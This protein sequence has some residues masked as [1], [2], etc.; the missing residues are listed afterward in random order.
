[1]TGVQTCALPISTGQTLTV[2]GITGVNTTTAFVNRITVDG[3]AVGI[4]TH[5]VGGIAPTDG[6]DGG[7]DLYTFNLLKTG[8]ATFIIVANQTKTS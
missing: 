7:V 5:W 8:E 3:R 6:G 4:T 2:T 1:M